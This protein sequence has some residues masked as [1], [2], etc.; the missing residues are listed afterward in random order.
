M[1]NFTIFL[2]GQNRQQ[3]S[4][5]LEKAKLESKTILYLQNFVQKLMING[6]INF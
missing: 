3:K 6:I 1:Q 5:V 4:S 2:K